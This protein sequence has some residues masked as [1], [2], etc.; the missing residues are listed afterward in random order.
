MGAT[1]KRELKSEVQN[2]SIFIKDLFFYLFKTLVFDSG[3]K[4][5]FTLQSSVSQTEKTDS[6]I[7]LD[8]SIDQQ[9]LHLALQNIGPQVNGD[10]NI[11]SKLMGEASLLKLVLDGFSEICKPHPEA[12]PQNNS[13]Y[14]KLRQLFEPLVRLAVLAGHSLSMLEGVGFTAH[15]SF[16]YQNI[17]NDLTQLELQN[18]F[19]IDSNEGNWS[20]GITMKSGMMFGENTP[21]RWH[22]D[23]T[24]DDPIHNM[25]KI[26]SWLRAN[27]L[28]E[29]ALMMNAPSITYYG[30]YAS[31]YFVEALAAMLYKLGQPQADGT[32]LLSF[33]G[34]ETCLMK[35]NGI[36]VTSLG[37]LFLDLIKEKMSGW[38]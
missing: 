33:A 26:A 35:I 37:T 32:L 23:I 31:T 16:E 3:Q 34:D 22:H 9:N 12:S 25:V 27:V 8:L 36:C 11:H 10:W 7:N 29:L 18:R 24:V 21:T 1:P 17:D 2:K 28:D 13:Y 20:T 30:S 5:H 15:G 38:W 6:S 14:E 4:F 19:Q